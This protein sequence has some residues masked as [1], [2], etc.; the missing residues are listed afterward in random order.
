MENK[1]VAVFDF[2]GTIVSKMTGYEF[3]KWLLQKSYIRA[4]LFF[5]MLPFIALLV[6]NSLTRK[7]GFTVISVIATAFQSKSLFR[8]RSEF[9]DHFF[10]KSGAIVFESAIEKIK[11]HQLQN[12]KVVIL[13][14]C[15]LWLLRG[16]IKYIGVQNCKLIGSELKSTIT[17]LYFKEHCYSHN[18]LVMAK[19]H[20]MNLETWRYGYSDSTSDMPWLKH[21]SQVYAINLSKR[22][23]VK[24][25]K[26]IN[27]KIKIKNV[28]WN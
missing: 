15:P 27:C 28:N 13:S 9:I 12:E 3:Y 20:G 22:N 6:T 7:H 11:K 24:F 10:S 18:K 8:I 26:F 2:D 23:S 5:I 16:I 21:C 25:N 1:S 17:G 14:G 4:A 19:K